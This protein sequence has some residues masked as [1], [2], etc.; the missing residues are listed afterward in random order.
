MRAKLVGKF[1]EKELDLKWDINYYGFMRLKY[2][3]VTVM[4]RDIKKSNSLKNILEKYSI[5]YKYEE[6]NVLGF[7]WD[8]EFILYEDMVS[9]E[10]VRKELK[11]YE[12]L[13]QI[14]TEFD[15]NDMDN[16]EWYEV[17]AR[18][19]QY[20]QPEDD[21]GYMKLTYN[22]NNWCPYCNVGKIQNNPYRL[23]KEPTQKGNQ[24]W[25]LFWEEEAIFCNE[26]IKTIFEKEKIQGIHFIQPVNKKSIPVEG[27]YQIMIEK[28]L[29][30]GFDPNNTYTK[31]C[32]NTNY[33]KN[34][35]E[36]KHCGKVKYENMNK[37]G[38]TFNKNVFS[39]KSD[40]YLSRAYRLSIISKKVYEIII[41]N[42][43][44]GLTIE[45]ILNKK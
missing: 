15:K 4:Q 8:L 32:N 44:K 1:T 40:L 2:R 17:F 41:K 30:N 22:L 5:K 10:K 24:F 28:T 31:I 9:F 20:P 3:Y 37:G 45:P 36:V 25:G 11:P 39:S 21:W 42:K 38:Y 34:N 26:A 12:L 23:K 33:P 13:E 18:P 7:H 14:S 19:S 43:L 35:L 6:N 29:D 16:A 27:Y